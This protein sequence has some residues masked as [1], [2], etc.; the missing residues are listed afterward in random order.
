M[1]K[2]ESLVM[3]TVV[4]YGTNFYAKPEPDISTLLGSGP[5][6]RFDCYGPG[7]VS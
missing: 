6:R 2:I 5:D 3:P 1:E 4:L 7:R